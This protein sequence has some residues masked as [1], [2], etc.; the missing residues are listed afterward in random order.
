MLDRI[1]SM[2]VFVKVVTTGSFT[3]AGRALSLSQTMVTKHINALETRLG[4]TLFHRSTRKLSLTDAGRLFLEGCQKIL[5]ELEDIEQTVTEQRREPR[6]RLR[7][8]APVSFAIRYVAPLL[9]EFSRRY[10]LVTVEL[11]VNDRTVDLIEEGWDLTLR[12]RHLT[13]SSLRTRKLAAIH[14]AV[15]AAPAYLEQAGTPTT[16]AELGQHACLGYTLGEAVGSASRWIFGEHGEKSVMISGPLCANNG[17]VLRE[18]AIAGQGIIYQPT[19]MVAD[20]LKTGSLTTLT[21][22]VPPVLGPPLHAV[23]APGL[24]TP[25]KVRVMIDFLASHYGPVP[26]WDKPEG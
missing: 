19:F 5:P 22:D 15:C 23:Y 6:G 25:L 11:G 9:P 17:D 24:T 8:N 7:L 26:P 21:L 2:Q 20:A 1:T 4:S 10:P 16:V 13:P 18:A 14:M 3:G 12:I